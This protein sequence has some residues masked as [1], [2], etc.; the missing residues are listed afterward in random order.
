M[1]VSPKATGWRGQ[2]AFTQRS[3]YHHRDQRRPIVPTPD[4][5]RFDPLAAA[6]IVAAVLLAIAGVEISAA[7][8]GALL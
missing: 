7:I 4:H 1:T 2:T 6:L 3:E 5:R 8:V